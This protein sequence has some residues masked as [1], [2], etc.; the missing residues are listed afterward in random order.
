MIT[1]IS[2]WNNEKDARLLGVLYTAVALVFIPAATWSY[3]AEL[4]LP[5]GQHSQWIALAAMAVV[6]S[7]IAVMYWRRVFAL[8]RRLRPIRR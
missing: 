7:S 4:A 6:H 2:G 8:R 3:C 5:K 1:R